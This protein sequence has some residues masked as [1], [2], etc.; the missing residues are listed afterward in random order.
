MPKKPLAKILRH[1]R[2]ALEAALLYPLFLLARLLPPTVAS[3]FGAALGSAIGRFHGGRKRAL[4]NLA[5]AL[6]EQAAAHHNILR[7][8]W[9][10]MGRVL[11]EYAHLSRLYDRGFIT[12]TNPARF[13]PDRSKP[14]VFVA[15]HQANWE[16]GPL[17]AARFGWQ[18]AA[19]Y[20][21]LNNRLVDWLLRRARRVSKQTLYPKSAEGALALLR[22]VKSGGSAA[23]LIDQRLGDGI[24]VPFFGQPALSPPMAALLAI[25]YGATLVPVEIVRT[26]GCHFR[27]T[28]HDSP[29][30]PPPNTSEA[31]RVQ[32][33]TA[34]LYAMFETWIRAHPEQWLWSHDR[35]RPSSKNQ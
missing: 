9:Q 26:H 29:P 2:Y 35:W 5:L 32:A 25:K 24:A 10:N 4:K 15:I 23:L 13:Q 27:M 30:L 6:P 34:A 19:I 20:R 14:Y 33:L 18:L 8:M 22:H 1:A 7:G 3:A 21:P 11:L 17:V 31:A 12:V 16:I 28:I